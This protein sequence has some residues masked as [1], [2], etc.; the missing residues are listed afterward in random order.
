MQTLTDK[1]FERIYAI[2][3]HEDPRF[4]TTPQEDDEL[5]RKIMMI[6]LMNTEIV[7]PIELQTEFEKLRTIQKID[8]ASENQ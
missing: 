5:T 6:L 7:I 3:Y 2:R 4:P 1:E 8:F